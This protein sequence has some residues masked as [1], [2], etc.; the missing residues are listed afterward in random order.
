MWRLNNTFKIT[1][2]SKKRSKEKFYN[3]LNYMKMKTTY[4]N[5]LE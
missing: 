2:G 5:L 4:E 1:H 3:I